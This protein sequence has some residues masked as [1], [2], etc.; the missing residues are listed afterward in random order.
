MEK[1]LFDLGYDLKELPVENNNLCSSM[2]HS[3]RTDGSLLKMQDAI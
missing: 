2:M 3:I 1:C